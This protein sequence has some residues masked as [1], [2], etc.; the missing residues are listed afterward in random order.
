[1]RGV[2]AAGMTNPARAPVGGAKPRGW[3]TSCGPGSVKE[4]LAMRAGRP[5]RA[6]LPPSAKRAAMAIMVIMASRQ[7]RGP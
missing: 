5:L 2:H 4:V 1:M 7:G 6:P 3:P